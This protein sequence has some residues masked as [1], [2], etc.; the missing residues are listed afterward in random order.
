LVFRIRYFADCIQNYHWHLE[1][2]VDDQL[3]NRLVVVIEDLPID[4]VFDHMGNIKASYGPESQ[5]I[6]A[7]QHLLKIEKCWVKLSSAYRL[8]KELGLSQAVK[9]M[10]RALVEANPERIVWGSDWPHTPMHGKDP[11]EDEKPLPFRRIDTGQLLDLLATWVPEE[12]L[13]KKIMVD[14]PACLYEFS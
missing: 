8:D 3:L 5:G 6:R 7:L 11:V 13:L 2:F 10:A 1:L 4:V 9:R 12:I 14:N